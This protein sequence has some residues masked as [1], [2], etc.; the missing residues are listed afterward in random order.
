[1]PYTQDEGGRINN[2][3]TEPRVYPARSLTPT[4]KRNYII[5]AAIAV[6]LVAG[7][8]AV[9]VFASRVSA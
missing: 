6:L 9:A 3:A 4:A 1:M 8:I 2:F 5:L 7:L